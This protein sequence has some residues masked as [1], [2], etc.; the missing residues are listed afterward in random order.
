MCRAVDC[1]NCGLRTWVGCGR[2]IEV[3][4]NGVPLDKR[5]SGWKAGKCEGK[6]V[7]KDSKRDQS[8]EQKST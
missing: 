7:T 4:L 8:E 6:N 5:C 2:H 1:D 3:A